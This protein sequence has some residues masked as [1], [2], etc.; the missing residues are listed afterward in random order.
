MEQKIRIR[1][2]ISKM[3]RINLLV[4][5]LMLTVATTFAQNQSYDWI[6]MTQQIIYNVDG[7]TETSRLEYTYDND[8]RET[9]HKQYY[10]GV[11][12]Y[13]YRD[14]QYNG[15]TIIC[16]LDSYSE[17]NVILSN[18]LQ[19][20]YCDKNWIQMTQYIL[21]ATD[22]V[23]EVYRYEYSYDADGRETSYKYYFNGV[24][25]SQNRDYQYNGR[26]VNYWCDNYSGGSVTS[27]TKL[28]RTYCDKN[29]IQMT[30]MI[31]YA[32]DGVTETNR[33]EYTYDNDGRETGYKYYANGV[34]YNQ[35][36]NYQYNGQTITCWG[37]TYSGGSVTSSSKI[38][39]TYK[40]KAVINHKII[41]SAGSN[42]IISPNGEIEVEE[43]QSKTFTF[44]A[45]SGY[46]IDQVLIDGTNNTTAVTAGSYTFENVTQSHSISVSFKTVS[47]I[48][49]VL[50]NSISIYPHPLKDEL[51]IESGD[52][53]I[54]TIQIL[55]ITGKT[56]QQIN[57]IQRT[58]NVSQLSGGIY[59]VKIKT[60]KGELT[61][62]VIKN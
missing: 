26:T 16:W 10:S 43:G 46:E 41:A 35:Y 37:D 45:N 17:G 19:R 12:S 42:G 1:S 20:K 40:E 38:Q 62:K 13:Q 31:Y 8:G 32:A 30:K 52:L 54:E 24:L 7:V 6:Q 23:T 55:D 29:W 44:S 48:S 14:Y 51:I 60:N 15:R 25:S 2:K 47:G 33:W 21:Y 56:I 49:E 34:L 28:Q 3:K 5:A 22:D 50:S 53:N 9:G 11:L 27:S 59:F 61:K 36:R 39:R 58:I 4:A 57:D 18:K